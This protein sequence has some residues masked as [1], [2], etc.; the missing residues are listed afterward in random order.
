[1]ETKNLGEADGLPPIEWSHVDAQ[2]TDLLTHD[3]P[4]APNR[5]GSRPPF[6]APT[7]GPPPW[8]VDEVKPRTVT[9]VGTTEAV[10][11]STRWRF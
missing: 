10:P 5:A 3:D 4:Q 1:M 2:L 11:G 6:N 8:F 9:A 7:L